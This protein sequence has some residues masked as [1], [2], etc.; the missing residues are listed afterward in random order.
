MP[1]YPPPQEIEP[2]DSGEL[3]DILGDLGLKCPFCGNDIEPEDEICPSCGRE[4]PL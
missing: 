1:Q 2:D 3:D 4:I